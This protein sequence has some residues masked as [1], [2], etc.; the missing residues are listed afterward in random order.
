MP[1]NPA[2][3]TLMRASESTEN[4]PSSRRVRDVSKRINYLD[5]SAA[6]LTVLS[7]KASSESV[8]NPK[9]EWIEKDLPAR[10]DAI[11]NG[12]GYASG[13]TSL[14][15]D[16]ATYFSVGD[17]VNVARTAEKMLVTTVTVG[18]NTL[19]VTRG[20]GTTAAAAIVDNDDLQIIGNAYAEGAGAGTE[21]SHQETYPYNYTQIIRTPFGV[22]GTETE[23]ENYTGPDKPRLRA[24]KSIEHMIDIERTILFGERQIN[25]SS[26]NAPVRYTG[27]FLYY[28]TSNLKDFGGVTTEAE[29]EDW[30]EDLFHYT[31]GSD[32]RFLT[33]AP[34][35]ISVFDQLGVARLQLVPRDQTLG[36][37]V[38]QFV[39]SHGT[40][41]ITKHRL[42]ESGYTTGDGYGAYVLAIDPNKIGYRFMRNRNTK[43]RMDIQAPDIDGWKDEYLTEVGW[44]VQNP[45]VHG[46]GKNITG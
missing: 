28:A 18:T 12:A 45:Q 2:V 41:M 6:P 23:A 30:C 35:P 5:P 25:T 1:H 9:F 7:K 8:Y 17:L 22:T 43:L 19:V 39:T 26:T 15:V 27:G 20:V 4:I 13:A 36:L 3:Q 16:H 37:S 14:V 44:V 31:G 21:K 40:L 46:V 38:K 10:W 32:T 24:E 33:A 29:V 11:N 42:L 34:Q